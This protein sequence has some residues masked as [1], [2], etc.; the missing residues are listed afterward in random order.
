LSCLI[1]ADGAVESLVL[2]CRVFQR[3]VEHAFFSWLIASGLAPSVLRFA[4]TPR[5]EPIQRFFE[6][7]GFIRSEPG[8]VRLDAA[9]FQ[10]AHSDVLSLYTLSAPA[11]RGVELTTAPRAGAI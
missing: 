11:L 2:S 7:D 1:T 10:A 9:S 5:N 8:V 6:A 3:R 4:E